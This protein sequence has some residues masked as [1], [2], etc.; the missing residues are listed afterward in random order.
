MNFKIASVKHSEESGC[1]EKSFTLV[2]SY[3]ILRKLRQCIINEFRHTQTILS[4]IFKNRYRHFLQN[5]G[6]RVPTMYE[7]KFLM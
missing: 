2:F 3:R 5:E 6:Y 1:S 7:R 4:K